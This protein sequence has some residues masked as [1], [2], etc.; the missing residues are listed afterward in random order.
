MPDVLFRAERDV[1]VFPSAAIRRHG[2]GGP[3][4]GTIVN[5]DPLPANAQSWVRTRSALG[6]PNVATN[7]VSTPRQVAGTYA[8]ASTPGLSTGGA[9]TLAVRTDGTLWGWGDN[10]SGRVG[11]GHRRPR[12]FSN[13]SG[14]DTDWAAV[15]GGV[16][17]LAV[18]TDG[19]LWGWG[20]TTPL[21]SPATAAPSRPLRVR[22]RSG[23]IPTGRRKCRVRYSLGVKTDGS[24]LGLSATTTIRA[25]WYRRRRSPRR[26]RRSAPI[27]TGR[28][29]NAGYIFSKPTRSQ[30]SPTERLT[31]QRANG[32]FGTDYLNALTPTQVGTDTDF[33]TASSGYVHLR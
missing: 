25:A 3:A 14:T 12:S 9:R 24:T 4:I 5:D 17:T 29:S 2:E 23:P 6:D 8:M 7:I 22:C 30:S 11:D 20:S 31:H 18:K 28:S 16:H 1:Q 33:K 26:R 21:A 27:P 10:D 15:S 13:Q 32:S 19:T